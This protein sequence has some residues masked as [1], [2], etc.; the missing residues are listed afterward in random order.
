MPIL[1]KRPWR[2]RSFA[3]GIASNMRITALIG[4]EINGEPRKIVTHF[5]R[6][7]FFY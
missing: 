3:S 5:A 4:V 2:G 6:N 1:P 7:G